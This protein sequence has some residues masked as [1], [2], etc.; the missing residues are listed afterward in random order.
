MI[1]FLENQ[2]VFK[3]FNTEDGID[4]SWYHR[5]NSIERL[6]QALDDDTI[7]MIEAD[8]VFSKL[9]QNA[10]Q[11]EPLMGHGTED[12][13]DLTVFHF[14]DTVIAQKVSLRN[15]TKRLGLYVSKQFKDY[16]DKLHMAMFINVIFCK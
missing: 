14:I 2:D 1:S 12:K 10:E 13:F 9:N 16:L 15:K 4:I 6:N 3:Y 11:P 7:Q 8:V 5:A